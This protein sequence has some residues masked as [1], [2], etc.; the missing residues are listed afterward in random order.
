[1][2]QSSGAV[3]SGK[4]PFVRP[5]VPWSGLQML[6]A[7]FAILDLELALIRWVGTQIRI[8][9]YFA[10]LVLIGAFLGMGLGVA[11]GRRR[12]EW[13]RHV[14][15]A[16]AVLVG[17]LSL[18]EPCGFSDMRFPDPAISLWGGEKSAAY[19]GDFSRSVLALFACFWGIVTIFVF[20]GIPVGWLFARMKPL[21]AYRFDVL[22]SLL[23]V[24]VISLCSWLGAPP[25]VWFGAGLIA[26]LMLDL[27][28]L[29][30]VLAVV[31]VAA[32]AWSSGSAVFSPYN[33]IDVVPMD[34]QAARGAA[35]PQWTL[36]VNR[37]FHQFMHDLRMSPEE[38]AAMKTDRAWIRSVYELPFKV[39]DRHDRALVVGAGTGND[40]AAA[41]RQGFGQVL[42]VDIDP[43]IIDLGRRLH[44]EQ[45][46]SDPR[47]VP[48][49]N[50]ARAFFS[51]NPEEKFD[52]VCYGLLDSHAMFS[53]MSS[54]RLDNYV[55]TREGIASGWQ[56]VNEQGVL[57][58]SFSV[59]GGDWVQQRMYRLI[60]Q[61]TGIAP[62]VVPHGY[63]YGTTFI[64]GRH[65]TRERVQA[66]YPAMKIVD[67]SEDV[68]VAV[69]TD[70]WP[71]LYL[72]PHTVPTTYLVV[73]ALLALS[74]FSVIRRVY[75][76]ETFRA[77]TFDLQMFLLGTAFMLM[78]TRMVTELSLLFG[79]TWVVNSCVFA[80]VLTMVLAANWVAERFSIRN[81]TRWYWP[82]TLSLMVVTLFSA[83]VL[84]QLPLLP[85]A[86]LAG[87]LFSTP[88]FFAGVIFSTLLNR[89]ANTSSAL[90]S[91]LCGATLGGLL[92]YLSTILGMKAI[93]I[94]A[95]GIYLLSALAHR[96]GTV[97]DREAAR[98]PIG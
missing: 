47:A 23:G 68:S 51:Q 10:N 44:P 55:Y 92:E 84:N 77:G 34:K 28:P 85:R 4:S 96:S 25:P 74:S 83:G 70:D 2:N 73:L 1:M 82:L 6:L 46:Y 30:V 63:N 31:V 5:L 36:N 21:T 53:A 45:P 81:I 54:L 60:R 41:L 33:R 24:L 58:V 43:R 39:T 78:E 42:S 59:F 29:N 86:L 90:G 20:A 17:I 67:F 38:A 37:D 49:V 48:V 95:L 26:L 57:S 8:A 22:G 9:A 14:F 72:R 80:G 16:L 97:F 3:L 89:R 12:P 50:D 64:V 13:F 93:T 35:M 98:S 61:A 87:A 76:A 75:G 11:L 52:V 65:L 91:N 19:W 18:A 56:H 88:V 27:R 79:S 62:V 94:L 66:A 40:V 15:V 32:A 69:P 7:T 71:F